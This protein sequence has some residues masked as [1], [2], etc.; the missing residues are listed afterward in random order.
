LITANLALARQGLGTIALAPSM[1]ASWH[2][3]R[4]ASHTVRLILED[5][6]ATG[7]FK[8][9]VERTLLCWLPL[10][11]ENPGQLVYRGKRKVWPDDVEIS[12]R[13]LAVLNH[14]FRYE[15]L[16]ELQPVAWSLDRGPARESKRWEQRWRAQLPVVSEY[17][18]TGEVDLAPYRT[19]AVAEEDAAAV[20][21]E[22]LVAVL[23]QGILDA[24]AAGGRFVAS[25]KEDQSTLQ[26][27]GDIWVYD[28]V[29]FGG[30]GKWDEHKVF[31][32][33]A[34]V[35]DFAEDFCRRRC[36]EVPQDP[37]LKRPEA[38]WTFVL[39]QIVYPERS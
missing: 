4:M 11:R 37:T 6:R 34:E 15:L 2:N 29:E 28:Y 10:E 30:S 9:H 17:V 24:L 21:D 20:P 26:Q 12:L 14:A 16:L 18:V 31:R 8:R 7:E 27:R 3:R 38:W 5:P 36:Y 32:S 1:K 13:L 25:G 33:A 23:R 22:E 39:G 35:L 19:V